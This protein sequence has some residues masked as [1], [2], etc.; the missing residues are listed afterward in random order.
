MVNGTVKW[1]DKENGFGFIQQ[2]EGLDVL[3]TCYK[4]KLMALN[5]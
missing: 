3:H 2:E 1:F 4:F 5:S